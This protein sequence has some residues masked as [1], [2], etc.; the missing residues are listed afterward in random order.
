MRAT[1]TSVELYEIGLGINGTT[2]L[3]FSNETGR[4]DV[5]ILTLYLFGVS[6][7]SLS[8]YCLLAVLIYELSREIH[9]AGQRSPGSTLRHDEVNRKLCTTGVSHATY[10]V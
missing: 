10:L 4:T 5:D 7:L 3:V 9:S 1:V 8:L 6:P 2:R